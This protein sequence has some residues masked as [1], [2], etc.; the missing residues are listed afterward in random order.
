MKVLI[1]VGCMF[2]YGVIT[3]LLK[4]NGILL[5][6]IPTALLVFGLFTLARFLSNAWESHKNEK[7]ARSNLASHQAQRICKNCGETLPPL[8]RNCPKC[9]TLSQDIG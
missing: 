5:G 9:G 7:E 4:E 1:W 8:T 6:A 2:A 3:V